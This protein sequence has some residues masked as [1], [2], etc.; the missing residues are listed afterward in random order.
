MGKEQEHYAD[1]I[2][3]LRANLDRV[4]QYRIPAGLVG[5]V[6]RGSCVEVPFGAGNQTKRAY[7]ISVGTKSK[8]APEKLKEIAGLS[9]TGMDAASSLIKL[10]GWMK[11]TYGSGMLQALKTTMPVRERKR[12]AVTET[13]SVKDNRTLV[14]ELL[15]EYERKHQSAKARLLSF[16]MKQGSVKRSDLPK[17]LKVTREVIRS[18]ERDGAIRVDTREESVLPVPVREA[19]RLQS[20]QTL[21][22][23]QQAVYEGILES[24][25]RDPLKP[26]LLEGVTGS[27]KTIV[28]MELAQAMLDAGREVIVLIPEI[29]LSW[30]TVTRFAARFGSLVA[31]LNS[32]MGE[33]ERFEELERV[34]SGEAKI[35]IGPRSALFTP[36]SH[37]GL[38]IVD[39]EQESAYQSD[40][41]PRYDA[42]ETAI[43]RGI[44][45]QASVLFGS[46]TPSVDTWYRCETGDYNLFRLESRYGDAVLPE[47]SIIDMRK[48]LREG[49]TSILSRSLQ[50]EIRKRLDAHEQ[51]I[52]FLNKRG[53]TSYVSCRS[54]GYV[55]KCPHCDVSLTAH[56]NGEMICHYCGY[57]QP[58][59]S[60]CPVCG[61]KHIGGARA[62]TEQVEQV[63]ARLF[64]DARIL[65]MDSD[66]TRG[67]EGHTRLVR[68]FAAHEADIL[69]GTQ[70]IVKGHDFPEVTLVGAVLADLSLFDNDYRSGERTFALL[71]QAIGRAGRGSRRGL[72][73]IQTYQGDEPCIE[74]AA[75]QDYPAFYREE[76]ETRKLL[77]YPPCGC[78]IAVRASAR[79]E[80]KLDTA[81]SYMAKYLNMINQDG[82]AGIIGPAP[83]RIAKLKD[84][85]RRVLYI[86]ADSEKTGLRLRALL[87]AY[88]ELN[89][90]FRDVSVT[91]DLN[92]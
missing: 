27:G 11:S 19:D 21:T 81:M 29:A 30:Q 35:V 18:L 15:S 53:Y 89:S 20:P 3:D 12:Q 2:V 37:L 76:I 33:R 32:R 52:L 41:T 36:F 4:F 57:R 31:V 44:I 78:M 73:L 16:L 67:K 88:I 14:S 69:I 85:Y 83:E 22:E 40:E 25:R 82:K 54:C 51:T 91:Y 58:V 8:V 87:E 13:L 72:A 68:S 9:S 74:A 39:E 56:R 34:R 84:F 17:E 10:A 66:T 63:V 60:R 86:K 6:V 70:M 61:S 77:H 1:V 65:R 26:C 62:G 46:A 79:S 7:V 55:V 43:A 23:E 49:N 92:R 45:E 64:P 80:E 28:Y 50:S 48:E 24:F 42:R 47:V 90:G 5:Q 38:M 59:L 71:V 75:R